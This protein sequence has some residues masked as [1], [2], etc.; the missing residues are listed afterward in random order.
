MQ[1][2]VEKK[3]RNAL[4]KYLILKKYISKYIIAQ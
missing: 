1:K 2:K 3:K 4:H